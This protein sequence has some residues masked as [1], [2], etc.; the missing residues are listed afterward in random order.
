MP[1]FISDPVTFVFFLF[2]F[3]LFVWIA[4]DGRRALNLLFLRQ[5]AVRNLPESRV[6]LLRGIA[7]IAAVSD[8]VA[9]VQALVNW[10]THH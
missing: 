4:W 3:G 7:L 6:R 9:I 2:A 10:G 5:A 8:S 1:V